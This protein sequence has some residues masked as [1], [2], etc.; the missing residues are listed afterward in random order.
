MGG[1]EGRTIAIGEF[2]CHEVTGSAVVSGLITVTKQLSTSSAHT[3]KD[4]FLIFFL[5]FI[6]VTDGLSR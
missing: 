1:G 3:G 4:I 2:P 5:V 6:L